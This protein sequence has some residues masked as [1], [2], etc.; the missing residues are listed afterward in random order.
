M[1]KRSVLRQ[2]FDSAPGRL[3]LSLLVGLTLTSLYVVF[4]YPLDFGP[5]RWSNPAVWSDNPSAAPLG[6][7]TGFHANLDQCT[8]SQKLVSQQ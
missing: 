3:G 1:G 8:K 7:R 2:L 4:T 6:G 5:S